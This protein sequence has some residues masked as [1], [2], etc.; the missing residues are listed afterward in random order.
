MSPLCAMS[1]SSSN[2]AQQRPPPSTSKSEFCFAGPGKAVT[3]SFSLTS[4][5]RRHLG[6]A[7]TDS[8]SFYTKMFICGK[9]EENQKRIK[10][11]RLSTFRLRRLGRSIKISTVHTNLFFHFNISDNFTIMTN[12]KQNCNLIPFTIRTLR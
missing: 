7:Q 3:I 1:S 5:Q 11:S 6:R 12:Y 9:I 8:S 10:N 4:I 2:Y